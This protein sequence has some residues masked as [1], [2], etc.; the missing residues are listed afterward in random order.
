MAFLKLYREK[1]KHNYQFLNKLFKKNDIEWGVVSKLLCG[2]KIFIQELYDLGVR[3]M[4]D[5]RISNLKAIKQIADDIQTVYI[6]PVP[7]R[8]IANT[9]KYA[10][11]SFNT[12]FS[13][14]KLL[15]WWRW[16]TYEKE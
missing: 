8:S 12:D 16:V 4:H 1:L 11:V 14:I 5:T 3:E 10:D 6:K 7:K 9:V 2:N 15:S 13:T